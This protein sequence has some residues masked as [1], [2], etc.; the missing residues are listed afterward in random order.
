MTNRILLLLLTTLFLCTAS[1]QSNIS[2]S[3]FNAELQKIQNA[4]KTSEMLKMN[5]HSFLAYA[6]K[7][8]NIDS[9]ASAYYLKG[10][11]VRGNLSDGSVYMINDRYSV[12]ALPSHR[13]MVIDTVKASE[14]RIRD[15]RLNPLQLIDTAMTD[16]LLS[17]RLSDY[18]ATYQQLKIYPKTGSEISEATIIYDRSSGRVR[19]S[20]YIVP[21]MESVLKPDS[22]GIDYVER[23][24]RVTM[25]FDVQWVTEDEYG[26]F[27]EQ[28]FFIQNGGRYEAVGPYTGYKIKVL[29]K[30]AADN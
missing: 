5:I 1:G 2:A 23:S 13:E 3:R 6:D 4:Y 9:S 27:N 12:Y 24:Y 11:L 28:A 29:F 30:E 16:S 22:S 18:D 21:Y 17:Y 26:W 7:P 25:V 14:L 20:E 15:P 19:V 8:G 10:D